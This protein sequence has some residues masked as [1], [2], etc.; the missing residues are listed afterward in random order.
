MRGVGG[1]GLFWNVY[2]IFLCL[3]HP[4]SFWGLPSLGA[5]DLQGS[6]ETG[7]EGDGRRLCDLPAEGCAAAQQGRRQQEPVFQ[8]LCLSGK[9]IVQSEQDKGA[10]P[11]LHLTDRWMENTWNQPWDMCVCLF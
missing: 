11:T 3:S 1:P 7:G 4:P 6:L 9:F 2:S 5:A 8:G 10:P